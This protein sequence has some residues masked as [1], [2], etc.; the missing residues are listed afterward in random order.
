[1]ANLAALTQTAMKAAQK[2]GLTGPLTITRPA[3]TTINP[4][5]GVASGSALTQTVTR[6]VGMK[7]GVLR[8]RGGA[9]TEAACGVFVAAS[10]LTWTPALYDQGTWAGRTHLITAIGIVNPTGVAIA[11]EF[12]L[13]AA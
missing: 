11:Y 13:G 3:G 1:M 5:T 10:D 7:P 12:A 2:A 9:W 6:A 8:A 4:T